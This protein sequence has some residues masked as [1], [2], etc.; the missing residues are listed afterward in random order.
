MGLKKKAA[1]KL[2]VI[3]KKYPKSK[4]YFKNKHFNWVKRFC[5]SK[6][7]KKKIRNRLP[8]KIIA[9]LYILNLILLWITMYATFT[10]IQNVY[11]LVF[12]Y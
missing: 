9:D 8:Y 5:A 6:R 11:T 1:K 4:K 2:Y 12:S 7:E 3:N 10:Y